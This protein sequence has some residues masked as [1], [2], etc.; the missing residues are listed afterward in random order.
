MAYAIVQTKTGATSGATSFTMVWSSNTTTG[1]LIVVVVGIITNTVSSI[2][3]SQSNTYTKA[4]N[5][6]ANS[7]DVE[8]WYAQNIT[9]GTTPTIT[10]NT[11]AS[12]TS[13]GIAQEYSGLTASAFDKAVSGTGI[14]GTASSGNTAA[15]TSANELIVGGVAMGASTPTAGAGYGN[16]TVNSTTATNKV[17]IED[18]RVTSTGAQAATFG[19]A[20]SIWSCSV[21]TFAESTGATF[22]A[23]KNK[24]ISQAVNRAS[25]Y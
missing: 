20:G 25:T 15:T 19:G 13:S 23:A 6:K 17:A 12:G 14:A 8:I 10:V 22:I 2:T 16:L 1:N 7:N 9:G 24:P 21:A 11:S 18:K 4:T 5:G 3:D